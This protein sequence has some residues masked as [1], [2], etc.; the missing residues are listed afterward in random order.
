MVARSAGRC[1]VFA[2]GDS[3]PASSR[4]I[5]PMC[6]A[7]RASS[8]DEMAHA[9]AR[10]PGVSGDRRPRV[11]CILKA[12]ITGLIATGDQRLLPVHRSI[13]WEHRTGAGLRSHAMLPSFAPNKSV[14]VW[15]KQIWVPT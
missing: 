2:P 10:S 9:V 3:G 13:L 1:A 8:P 6:H 4:D 15:R 7:G 5:I 11:G 12:R 14:F